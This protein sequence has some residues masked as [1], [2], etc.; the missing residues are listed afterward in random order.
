MDIS[1]AGTGLAYAYQ[2]LPSA[3]KKLACKVIWK[4]DQAGQGSIAALVSSNNGARGWNDLVHFIFDSAGWVLQ[5]FVG[6]LPTNLAS[7]SYSLSAEVEYYFAIEIDGNTATLTIPGL[8]PQVITDARIGSLNGRYVYFEPTRTN[9]TY[10]TPT[11]SYVEA[12]W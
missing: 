6:A 8:A 12:R 3:A 11:F 5:V 9:A 10:K 1:D 4:N 2:V 7:G